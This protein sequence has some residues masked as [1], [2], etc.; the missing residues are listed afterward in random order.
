MS[1]QRAT[2]KP[3]VPL[4][5]LPKREESLTAEEAEAAAGGALNGLLL[6]A[7]QKVSIQDGTS[8]TRMTDITDGTSNT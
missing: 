7:V 5:D 6:P 1:K 3:A 8:N 2:R 4:A